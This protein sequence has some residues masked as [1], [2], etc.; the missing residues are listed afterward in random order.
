MWQDRWN[1]S[2]VICCKVIVQLVIV[3]AAAN[4]I[5]QSAAVVIDIVCLISYA[6]CECVVD[7]VMM[8]L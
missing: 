2:N 8:W 1:A 7:Y 3:T 4:Q 6:L 5:G